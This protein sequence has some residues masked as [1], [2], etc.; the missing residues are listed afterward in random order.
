MRLLSVLFWAVL[1]AVADASAAIRVDMQTAATATADG[2]SMS[3]DDKGAAGLTVT[4]TFTATVTFEGSADGGT[5]WTTLSCIRLSTVVS[6]TTTTT[7]GQFVCNVGGLS[8]L[9]ARV[10]AYTNGSVT[11]VGTPSMSSTAGAGAGTSGLTFDSNGN[12]NINQATPT[13]CE[14]ELNNVC[15]TESQYEYETV[16]ASQTD[17]VMGSTGAAGDL[18]ARLHCVFTGAAVGAV[19]IKDGTGSAITVIDAKPGATTLTV[20]LGG[21]VSTDAGWKVTTGTNTTCIGIGRFN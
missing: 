8:H 4:G 15:R 14:D 6:T 1:L 11:V 19:Q 2:K 10:S 18:L 13:S 17:Q 5:T 3:V 7:T 20:D 12:L 21:M 16:A 9:R